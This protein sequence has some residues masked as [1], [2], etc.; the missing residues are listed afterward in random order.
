MEEKFMRRCFELARQ[1]KGYVA[2]NPLVGSVIVH[3]DQII[4]EG[5]HEMY[6]NAHAEVNAIAS[7]KDKSLLRQSTIYVNLEPCAHHG[8]TPPCADLIIEHKIPKVVVGCT[9][10]YE[11]VAGKGISRMKL[12]GIDVQVGLLEKEALEL[13]RRFFTFHQQKRPYVILKWAQTQDGFIDKIRDNDEKGNF[14]ITQIETKS[15]VHKWRHEEAG[16]LVGKNTIINDNPHLNVRE[17]KGT[18][19]SRFVIDPH[20]EI[21]I[22]KYNVSDNS[23]KTFVIQKNNTENLS[24]SEVLDHVHKEGIQSVI[25]E[26]GKYTLQ[27][28]ID[29]GLWDE[30]RILYGISEIKKGQTAPT[31]KGKIMK[32]YFYGKDK[33]EIIRNG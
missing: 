29:S 25:I 17:I 28:F 3:Q 12:T 8:K 33:I 6:G 18:S 32:S 31:I 1:G 15:L 2:P 24:V 4:G 21:D 27:Q 30:A 5:F 10:S 23:A 7:V 16:I 11:E 26:G 19:P 13:N 20:A 14:W 22:S 9:D